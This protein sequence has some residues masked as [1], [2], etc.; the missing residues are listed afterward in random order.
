MLKR[1]SERNP[2]FITTLAKI[3]GLSYFA[4][5]YW[6]IIDTAGKKLYLN[7]SSAHSCILHLY[8]QFVKTDDRALEYP[9]MHNPDIAASFVFSYLI[10]TL[11][12]G[13]KYMRNRQPGDMVQRLLCYYNFIAIN[14]NSFLAIAVSINIIQY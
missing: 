7:Y 14:V 10:L 2:V 8:N 1:E 4:N 12:V 13:P 5:F 3:P 9:M 6:K 11:M